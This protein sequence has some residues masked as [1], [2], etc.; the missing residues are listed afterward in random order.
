MRQ[1]GQERKENGS[2]LKKKVKIIEETV[3]EQRANKTFLCMETLNLK[4]L[5]ISLKSKYLG[6]M[7]KT[8]KKERI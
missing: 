4:A 8:K 2:K 1:K 5:R 6:K 7:K 3:A